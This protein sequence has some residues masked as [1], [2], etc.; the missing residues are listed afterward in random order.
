MLGGIV[1]A[2]QLGVLVHRTAGQSG[3]AAPQ[4]GF[5]LVPIYDSLIQLRIPT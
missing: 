2:G 3:P 4:P 1:A 5:A